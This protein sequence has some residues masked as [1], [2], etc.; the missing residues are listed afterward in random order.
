M[1]GVLFEKFR[2]GSVEL[3][4][5]FVRSATYE[6][7]AARD[8][9]VTP[10]LI[11]YYR[12]LGK[13]QIGAIISGTASVSPSGNGFPL[14]MSLERDDFIDGFRE[15]V[16][17]AKEGGSAFFVQLW[18]G[19]GQA[20]PQ[21]LGHPPLAPS[22]LPLGPLSMGTPRELTHEEI[23]GIIDDFGTAAARAMEA[24]ADGVQIHGAHGYLVAEFLSPYFNRRSDEWGGSPENRFRFLSEVIASVRS[25]AGDDVP[26]LVKIVH[27]EGTPEPGMTPELAADVAGRL[28]ELGIAGLE[29]SAGSGWAPFH[30]VRG[31]LPIDEVIQMFPAELQPTMRDKLQ[32][33]VE[34]SAFEP[35]FNAN[36]APIVKGRLEGV[37]FILVGG[38]RDLASMEELVS[39]GTTDLVSLC[40][41][42][43]RQP[44]LVK[45]FAEGTADTAT[46]EYCNRCLAAV[47]RAFPL[48]CYSDTPLQRH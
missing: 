13:G 42:L 11:H 7:M 16:S 1:G 29:L 22:S 6:S 27:H 20:N 4:N 28:S 34:D 38:L 31:E 9:A 2:L 43:I 44:H 5:R 17:T 30:S 19:G 14:A 47:F 48:R 15:M 25:H 10:Q 26:V 46:C 39:S 3:P 24:G 32:E 41:P 23:V 37:P 21:F 36:A 35:N 45:R 33:F 40:R 8:G 12:M 18:H